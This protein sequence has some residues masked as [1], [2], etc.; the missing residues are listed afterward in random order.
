MTP[1]RLIGWLRTYADSH[2]GSA[3]HRHIMR[4][5]ADALAGV[6]TK[7]MSQANDVNAE[8]ISIL[9]QRAGGELFIPNGPDIKVGTTCARVEEGGVRFRFSPKGTQ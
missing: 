8:A 5:A 4:I 7:A 9:A 3:A 2:E 6:P 1:E